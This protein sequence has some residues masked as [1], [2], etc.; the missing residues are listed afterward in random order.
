MFKSGCVIVLISSVLISSALLAQQPGIGSG[1]VPVLPPAAQQ[2]PSIPTQPQGPTAAAPPARPADGPAQIRLDLDRMDS[3]LSNMSSEIEF[4][5]DQNL[6]ILLRTNA[7]MWM[8]LIRDLRQ[9][10][11]REE[12]HP[13]I[14]PDRGTDSPKSDAPKA[15]PQ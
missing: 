1:P 10:L 5:H 4:L 11:A 2:E 15:K 14:E 9:Q 6:Q 8:L 3:L 7:Q 12:R 13:E